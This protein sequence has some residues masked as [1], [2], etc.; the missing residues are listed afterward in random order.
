MTDQLLDW[1][2]LVAYAET[3]EVRLILISYN[4]IV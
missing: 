2:E 3:L 4:L 1:T